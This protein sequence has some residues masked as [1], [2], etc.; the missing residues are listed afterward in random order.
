MI[1]KTNKSTNIENLHGG[2]GIITIEKCDVP[3][4]AAFKSVVKVTVPTGASIGYHTHH[5]D[6][7][8]YYIM[9]GDGIFL[10]ERGRHIV[11]AGDFCLIERGGSHGVEN[12]GTDDMIIFATVMK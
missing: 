6:Y 11:T 3:G 12:T 1:Y 5:D 9:Q 7:E 2:R 10:D 8:G 4:H